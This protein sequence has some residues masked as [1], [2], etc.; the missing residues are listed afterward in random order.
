MSDEN[1]IEEAAAWITYTRTVETLLLEIDG[2]IA[3]IFS[4]IRNLLTA[5]DLRRVLGAQVLTSRQCLNATG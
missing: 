4:S 5:L 3:V 2:Y 1:S